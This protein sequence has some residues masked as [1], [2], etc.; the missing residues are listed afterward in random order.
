MVADLAR[1]LGTISGDI[2]W[3]KGNAYCASSDD[4]SC[5]FSVANLGCHPGSHVIL[6]RRFFL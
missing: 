2:V 4:E 5:C 3:M 6:N 1:K